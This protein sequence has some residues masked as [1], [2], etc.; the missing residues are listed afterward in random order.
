M[1]KNQFSNLYNSVDD[2]DKSKHEFKA[3]ACINNRYHNITITDVSEA[4][5]QQNKNKSAGPNGL[6]MESYIYA[7]DKQGRRKLS[8]RYGGRHTN[9]ER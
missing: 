4:V 5:G 1:W 7:G 3:N 2:G 8:G 6:Y 9:P